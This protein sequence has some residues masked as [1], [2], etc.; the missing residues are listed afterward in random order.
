[1]KIFG[2]VG[3][4]VKVSSSEL[5]F[6]SRPLSRFFSHKLRLTNF[7]WLKFDQRNFFLAEIRLE[8]FSADF[9][10]ILD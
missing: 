6:G 2:G 4:N 7:F 3:R 5:D 1:M 8:E 9:R 10:I